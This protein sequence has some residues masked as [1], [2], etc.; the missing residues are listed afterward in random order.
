ML[1]HRGLA[2]EAPENTLLAFV[3]A[4]G[5]G[6]THVETDV[7]ASSDGVAVI[8]HD[9]DLRRVAGIDGSV[10]AL[11][12]RALREIDLGH[13]QGF[14]SLAE[15]LDAFPETS[16][17]IDIKSMDA[18][19]PTVAAIRDARAVDRVLVTSFSERRRRAAVRA[20]PGVA[21][22][23]SSTV[24]ASALASARSGMTPLLRRILRTPA[25]GSDGR[26]LTHYFEQVAAPRRA[27]LDERLAVLSGAV[28]VPL[29]F[30]FARA[31]FAM[32]S[33]PWPSTPFPTAS[34]STVADRTTAKRVVP[35]S[36]FS[37]KRRYTTRAAP[38]PATT[39]T[40]T[41]AAD[42]SR[43]VTVMSPRTTPGYTGMNA[44]SFCP[45]CPFASG[46]MTV[47]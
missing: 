36:S 34:F 5:L 39:E 12:M 7:H 44:H 37:R 1:A 8:A 42:Q 40:S 29:A 13:E 46:S 20:L 47:G 11:S 21:T 38:N 17:N 30:L 41:E 6:V 2:V 22:S 23:A 4:I 33:P 16:F 28:G 24:F 10:G 14:V 32:L 45:M 15:A 35:L 3:A 9:P 31:D 26:M 27:Q 19:A 25:Q 43:P 18:V